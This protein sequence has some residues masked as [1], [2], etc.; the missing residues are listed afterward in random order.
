MALGMPSRQQ[1]SYRPHVDSQLHRPGRIEYNTPPNTRD[2]SGRSGKM[3][4]QRQH[5]SGRND[6]H[7]MT[8]HKRGMPPLLP[9]RLHDGVEEEE[10]D[11]HPLREDDLVHQPRAVDE[12]VDELPGDVETEAEHRHRVGNVS[13]RL[14][15]HEDVGCRP[16]DPGERGEGVGDDFGVPVGR[17]IGGIVGVGGCPRVEDEKLHESG[18]Q[19][20]REWWVRFMA[21]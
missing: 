14:D 17:G 16:E 4:A 5:T 8:L 9:G 15:G 20:R 11:K 19:V 12:A 1:L 2:E 10:I 3:E 13:V 21:L 7:D 6:S 18:F